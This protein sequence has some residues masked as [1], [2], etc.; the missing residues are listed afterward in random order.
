MRSPVMVH[1]GP[2]EPPDGFY[3]RDPRASCPAMVRIIPPAVLTSAEPWNTRHD[4]WL[5][6]PQEDAHARTFNLGPRR[7][8]VPLS[9][10]ARAGQP[11]VPREPVR[12]PHGRR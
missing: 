9:P 6:E 7:R 11:R 5:L 8:L 4:T 2:G 3:P 10:C 12:P 1:Y